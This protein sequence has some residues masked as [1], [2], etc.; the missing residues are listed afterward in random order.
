MGHDD[1]SGKNIESIGSTL[2]KFVVEQAIDLSGSTKRAKSFRRKV[3]GASSVV[4]KKRVASAA[5][6]KKSRLFA[7]KAS[8]G[9]PRRAPWK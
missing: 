2:T 4:P 5:S 9:I 6:G 8:S 7:R 1:R 3:S